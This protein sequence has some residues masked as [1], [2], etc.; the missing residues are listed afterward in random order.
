MDIL[1]LARSMS[2]QEDL[3]CDIEDIL[4]QARAMRSKDIVP[5]VFLENE[6]KGLMV[7]SSLIVTIAFPSWS[8]PSRQYW[9]R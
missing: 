2:G 4:Q 7:V 6:S 8:D 1:F 5:N 9:E 3:D